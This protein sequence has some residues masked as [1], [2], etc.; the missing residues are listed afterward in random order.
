MVLILEAPLP[1]LLVSEEPVPSVVFPEEVSVVN[2]PVDGVEAPIVVEFIVPPVI[3]TPDDASVLAVTPS[4]KVNAA[5]APVAS[6]VT[7]PV[8]ETASVA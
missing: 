1:K 3:V 5:P 6:K 8:D 2:D 4:E 7:A